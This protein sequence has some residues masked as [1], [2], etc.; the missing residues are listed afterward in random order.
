MT[1]FVQAGD[2]RIA[3]DREG[4]GPALLLMH[5]AEASRQMFAAL[6]PQL[7]KHFTVIAYDQRDCGESEGPEQAA[8]LADLAHD[9]HRFIKA[10]GL[11]RAHVFGSS[12]GGRVAQALALLHPQTVDRLVLASTWPL[13]RPYEELCPDANRIAEL[14]RG[15]PGTAEELATYFFPEAFLRQRPE[16]RRVFAGVRPESARSMRRAATVATTLENGVA[17][18]VAPT[19]VLAGELDR[20]VPASV[21]LGIAG[22]MRGADAVLLPSIGHAT[23]LQA[24]EVVASHML[25]FLGPHGGKS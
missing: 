3:Y 18:I 20:V 2:V 16:L 9:A 17:D 6:I 13:P 22:R 19:L 25:R 10:L 12:F 1:E 5:G 15:L 7:A 21:T 14:R 8:S 4:H 24:P 23:T 11:K